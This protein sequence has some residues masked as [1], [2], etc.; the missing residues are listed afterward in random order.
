MGPQLAFWRVSIFDNYHASNIWGRRSF[1]AHFADS[2]WSRRW[3]KQSKGKLKLIFEN[4]WVSK[5]DLSAL[6]QMAFSSTFFHRMLRTRIFYLFYLMWGRYL[7]AKLPRCNFQFWNCITC[8][9]YHIALR[10]RSWFLTSQVFWIYRFLAFIL[11]WMRLSPV[12]P[13]ILVL[14]FTQQ[15]KLKILHM[16]FKFKSFTMPS[17]QF[18]LTVMT[19]F[20][21]KQWSMSNFLT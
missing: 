16:V 3:Q 11:S 21:Q 14:L 15:R 12:I 6:S 8:I 20:V 1:R 9:A 13:K 5:R 7:H 10:I 17:K 4:Y 2:R 19:V 18:D